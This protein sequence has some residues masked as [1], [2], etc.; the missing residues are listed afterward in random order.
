MCG[1]MVPYMQPNLN[2]TVA[3][4][5]RAEMARRGEKQSDLAHAAGWTK[6]T[7]SRR[8]SGTS[9]WTATDLDR[10]ADHFGINVA[11]LLTEVRAAS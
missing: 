8:L 6:A 9:D 2:A 4:N 7:A 1:S 11:D 10:I 5:A 3:A